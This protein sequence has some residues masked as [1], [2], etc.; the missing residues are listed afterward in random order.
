MKTEILKLTTEE[1]LIQ[2][3]KGLYRNFYRL[4]PEYSR[5]FFRKLDD[6]RL[7]PLMPYKDQLIYG[8][9]VE[10][11]LFAAS[12]FCIN[13]ERTYEI[14]EMGFKIEK[15][16]NVCEGLHFYSHLTE[17]LGM[18]LDLYKEMAIFSFKDILKQNIDTIYSSCDHS[19]LKMYKY[20]GFEIIDEVMYGKEKEYLIKKT[21]TSDVESTLFKMDK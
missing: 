1:D 7:Q 21:V 20:M 18:N 10:G 4:Y 5:Q 2:H 14:E 13:N 17:T 19:R 3:E 8:I 12:S 15:T 16:P 9:K 6:R 11:K